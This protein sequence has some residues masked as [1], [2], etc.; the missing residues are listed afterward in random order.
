MT[1]LI[2][3][4]LLVMLPVLLYVHNTALNILFTRESTV[5]VMNLL[6]IIRTKLEDVWKNHLDSPALLPVSSL[7]GRF[8]GGVKR[9]GA[10]GETKIGISGG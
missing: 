3:D 2:T 9:W 8:A 10:L 1:N 6:I 4:L 5:L 7:Q